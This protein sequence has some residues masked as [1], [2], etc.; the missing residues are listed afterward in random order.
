MD[1]RSGCVD[2]DSLLILTSLLSNIVVKNV[3]SF[4]ADLD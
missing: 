1:A 3:G 4:A 2:P